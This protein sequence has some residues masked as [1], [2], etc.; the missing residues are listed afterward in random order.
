M[1]KKNLLKKGTLICALVIIFN[2]NKL[3]G[4]VG[5]GTTNPQ[6]AFD[7]TSTTSG[8]LFPRLTT[9]QRDAI[10]TPATGMLIFN[11]NTNTFDYNVGT[12]AT[13]N[14][15]SLSTGNSSST[16]S[17][18]ISAKFSNTDTNTDLNFPTG[19]NLL[20]PIFGAVEWNDDP[21]LFVQLNDETLRV[22]QSGRYRVQYNISIQNQSGGQ[23]D[24]GLSAILRVNGVNTGSFSLTGLMTN[25]A[26]HDFASLHLADVFEFSAN[27]VIS[28]HIFDAN[29]QINVITLEGVGTSTFFVERISD[30]QTN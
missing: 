6:A 22:T 15:V 13:P 5:V 7:V 17:A 8:V 3:S 20:T 24:A 14:W 25:N 12:P 26:R 29:S 30:I 27:D 23:T 9:L 21:S 11:S 16:S 2:L 28:I 10:P 1:K 18:P 4:Q 19:S